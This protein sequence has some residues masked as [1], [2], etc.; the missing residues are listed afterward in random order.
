MNLYK[1]HPLSVTLGCCLTLDAS[2]LVL[3]TLD[4]SKPES[5][6]P[7]LSMLEFSMEDSLML[8]LLMSGQF[9]PAED[10]EGS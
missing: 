6:T 1:V 10:K 2:T 7:G 3:E 4:S 9:N 8:E 5:V